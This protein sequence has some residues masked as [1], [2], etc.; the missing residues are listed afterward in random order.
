VT[1]RAGVVAGVLALGFP[2]NLTASV[3]GHSA[4]ENGWLT[5]F[6]WWSVFWRAAPLGFAGAALSGA[7]YALWILSRGRKFHG[8]TARPP[9]PFLTPVKSAPG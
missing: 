8:L 6:G 2:W 9:P 5:P 7:A 1:F 3:D 4:M